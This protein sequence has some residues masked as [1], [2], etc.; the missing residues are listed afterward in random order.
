MKSKQNRTKKKR[1]VKRGVKQKKNRKKTKRKISY[2]RLIKQK[3]QNKISKKNS[4]KL[5]RLLKKNYCKCIK[6][7]KG[8]KLS[9]EGIEY[10][11]CI[12]SIYKNRGFTPPYRIIK[13]CK[14]P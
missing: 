5:D 12:S 3:L 2:K 11:I 9:K 8:K 4:I 10:P 13:S 6:S 7:L 1:G 14:R